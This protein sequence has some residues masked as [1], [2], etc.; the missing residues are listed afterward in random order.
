M[1]THQ[2]RVRSHSSCF[3]CRCGQ[4]TAVG[5][6]QQ[7]EDCRQRDGDIGLK[8]EDHFGVSASA[9]RARLKT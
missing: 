9:R 3:F 4:A 1:I 6:Q 8:I 7:A 2:V 5:N